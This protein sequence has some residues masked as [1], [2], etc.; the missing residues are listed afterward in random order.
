M[1]MTRLTRRFT[2]WLAAFAVLLAAFAPFISHAMPQPKRAAPGW[3]EVCTHTGPKLLKL[4][5]KQHAAPSTPA[6]KGVHSNHCSFCFTHT[7]QTG[8]PPTAGFVL[9]IASGKQALPR[10][11]DRSPRPLFAWTNAPSRAPPALS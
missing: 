5:D 6:E 10:L 9:P 8:L 11:A 2:A 4:N 7:G 1:E 3:V